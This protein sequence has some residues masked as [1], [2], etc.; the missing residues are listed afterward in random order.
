VTPATADPLYVGFLARTAHDQD[1]KVR[2]ARTTSPVFNNDTFV[3]WFLGYFYRVVT[4]RAE[5]V[6]AASTLAAC[7]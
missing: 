2:I 5:P 1:H 7:G 4:G 3:K 6:P